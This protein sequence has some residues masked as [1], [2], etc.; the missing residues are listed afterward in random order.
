VL[1]LGYDAVRREEKGESLA[2]VNVTEYGIAYFFEKQN[3]VRGKGK[4]LGWGHTK[5]R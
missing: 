3:N 2:F 1:Y 5:I 4:V